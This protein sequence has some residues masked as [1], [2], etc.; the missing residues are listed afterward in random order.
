MPEQESSG[1]VVSVP[2][3]TDPVAPAAAT[4]ATSSIDLV[5]END[6]PV[7]D[8][9]IREDADLP[10]V[11]TVYMRNHRYPEG[12]IL[13][14]PGLGGIPNMGSKE[15][16]QVQVANYESINMQTFNRDKG[17]TIEIKDEEVTK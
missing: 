14:V 6:K 1:P 15:V 7:L 8:L 4:D 16:D 11:G 10:A 13:E 12:Y 17:L 2:K 5:D 9:K 3:D